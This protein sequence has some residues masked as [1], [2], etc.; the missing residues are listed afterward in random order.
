MVNNRQSQPKLRLS[1]I[2]NSNS[3][4]NDEISYWAV[5]IGCLIIIKFPV[6]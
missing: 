5:V 6:V 2:L 1:T 4:V 3:I